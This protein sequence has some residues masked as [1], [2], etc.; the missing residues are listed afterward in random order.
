MHSAQHQ[1]GGWHTGMCIHSH[2]C[3]EDFSFFQCSYQGIKVVLFACY[4][5][6]L[7]Q[8]CVIISLRV[9]F[10]RG[11]K[12]DA[13]DI[14][15]ILPFFA[16]SEMKVSLCDNSQPLCFLKLLICDCSQQCLS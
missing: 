13:N 12:N 9:M 16:E 8:V 7:G 5:R 14:I 11:E 10:L 2:D 1:N 3:F 6:D 15:L 4:V